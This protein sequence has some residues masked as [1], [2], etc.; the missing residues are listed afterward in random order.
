MNIRIAI[1]L[2]QFFLASVN[3]AEN[4]EIEISKAQLFNLGVKLGQLESVNNIPLLYA[5]ATVTIPPGEEYIISAA[6]AGLVSQLNVA[7]GD[8]VAKDQILALIKSPE[9]LALQQQFLK[10]SSGRRLAKAGFDRD[11]NLL[12]EGVIS[13]RRWQETRAGYY[14]FVSE[15]NELTQLLE[16]SGLSKTDIRQLAI[17]RKLSSQLKVRTPI[18]GVVLERKVVAGE[19]IDRLAP[20]Y[21][22][23]NLKT[24]WLDIQI[25]QEQIGHLKIGDK[26]LINNSAVT[27]K[28][29]L[30]GQSVNSENQAILARA[31]IDKDKPEIRVG[32]TVTVQIIQ[33]SNKSVYKIPNAGIAQNEGQYYIFIRNDQGFLVKNI[34][35][36]GKESSHSIITGEL[37]GQEQI[38][39]RGAVALK[40]NWLGLG[41]DENSGGHSH[42]GH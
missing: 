7:I 28:I 38:A 29:T 31:V 23:A 30:L 36:I 32:Q 25:P 26:V 4:E 10:A 33:S 5:P 27:A 13:E 41:A 11:K 24:L 21:R 16:I 37:S 40:A 34:A 8:P 2:T 9:L 39:I 35:I 1:I 6:Q 12:A 20:L 42:G 3:A 17:T 18:S 22:I 19:R 15:V 14:G